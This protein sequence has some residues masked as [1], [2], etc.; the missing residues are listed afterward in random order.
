[1]RNSASRTAFLY[2]VLAG[3]MIM[4]DLII[5]LL[6][7]NGQVIREIHVIFAISAMLLLY[8]FL[9][10]ELRARERAEARHRTSEQRLTSLLD[11][12]I[13]GIIAV[14][15]DQRIFLFNQ[16]AQHLFGYSRQ[17]VIGQTLD[18]LLPPRF[19]D[20]HSQH[21]HDFTLMAENTLR[22]DNRREVFGRRKDGSEF[23]AEAGVSKVKQGEQASFTVILHDVTQRK[24]AEAALSRAHAELELRVQERT[25]ELTL[26]I[27]ALHAEIAERQRIEEERARLLVQIEQARKHAEE[28]AKETQLA[29]SMLYALIETMP[30]GVMVADTGGA[31]ILTNRSANSIVGG[32]VTGT[33]YGPRGGYTLRRIDGSHLPS[34]ELPLPRAI[35]YGEIT[36]N[37]EILVC[38]KDGV[39]VAILAAGSPVYDESGNII[40][41]VMVFQ[42]ITAHKRLQQELQDSEET[43][44]ALMNASPESALLVDT[45]G[46]VLAANE[47]AAL[48]LQTTVSRLIGTAATDLF[49]PQLAASRSAC[50]EEVV[51][52]GQ[53]VHF[54]DERL[55]MM[56][57]N[58]IQPICDTSGRVIRLAI[59]GYDVTERK[60]IE[61]QRAR[62]A[63]LEERQHLA[64]ELHD[65]LSQNLYGVALGT[66]TALAMLD[67]DKTKVVE[68]LDYILALANSG[69][70]ELRALIFD[71]RPESLALEGLVAAL[72]KQSAVVH[73]RNGI[74]TRA[75]LC[76]EPNA[77]LEIKEALYRIAQEALHNVVK[78]A[79]ASRLDLR[80]YRSSNDIVLEIRDDGV[81]FDP[82]TAFPGHLGLRSMDERAAKLGGALAIHSSPGSGTRIHAHFPVQVEL[83]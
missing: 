16:G 22:M 50:L 29:N 83:A 25:T 32:A 1:M 13:D 76:S 18:L 58:Y 6:A 69:L 14:G 78:H 63:A 15:E 47:V 59:F 68:A 9:S 61:D 11:T 49:P 53:P 75:D 28:L 57:D 27:A 74:E 23:P 82:T 64:R 7:A 71:L 37:I 65:T 41:G 36:K 77:P 60:Q 52:T 62:L 12:A 70:T 2:A 34:E 79:Q 54:E 33:A 42:D 35:Q 72:T 4:I 31:I 66:H 51:R 55:G 24:Q 43:A 10:R 30:A 81:G 19:A 8:F 3:L 67:T 21:F 5:D 39:E 17:E 46:R 38:R 26:S 48:R 73:A 80:L 45:L 44:R 56:M 40:S 20:V